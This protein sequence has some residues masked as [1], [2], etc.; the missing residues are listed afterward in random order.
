[1]QRQFDQMADLGEET[2]NPRRIHIY[3]TPFKIMSRFTHVKIPA[4]K[5]AP[6][7]NGSTFIVLLPVLCSDP[8][9]PAYTAALALIPDIALFGV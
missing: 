1:M 8:F 6:D 7:C 9:P 3:H 4:K 5:I 2:R